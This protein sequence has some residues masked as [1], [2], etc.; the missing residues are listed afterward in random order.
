VRIF[1]FEHILQKKNEFRESSN[2]S[3]QTRRREQ[4]GK[5]TVRSRDT[6]G[7]L[8]YLLRY[9][10]DH[11][12]YFFASSRR[13]KFDILSCLVSK[14]VGDHMDAKAVDDS[15]PAN[16]RPPTRPPRR[17]MVRGTSEQDGSHHS[18]QRNGTPEVAA[19]RDACR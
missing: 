2:L 16:G 5:E 12:K 4:L 1:F 11:H 8:S 9:K 18:Q 14:R 10:S 3:S 19:Q 17:D 13:L 7:R 6:V 15:P